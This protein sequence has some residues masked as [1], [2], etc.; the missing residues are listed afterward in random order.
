MKPATFVRSRPELDRLLVIDPECGTF[1][2]ARLGDLGRF[3]RAGD[4]VV[5]ND[6]ATLPA[7][8]DAVSSSGE[9]FELRLAGQGDS[10][11]DWTAV[12]LGAGPF[13]SRTEDRPP[14]PNLILS[15]RID[16]LHD[17]RRTGISQSGAHEPTL[18]AE[19][20]A[21]PHARLVR[22][23][24]DRE[25]AALWQALYRA[26]RPIQYAYVQ[27]PLSLWDV[28]TPFATRPWA[29][30]MP[31]AGR[32]LVAAV[33]A[34]L[35]TRGVSLARI[36]HAAGLSSTGDADLDARLP[37]PERYDVPE[38]TARAIAD[39]RARGGRVIAI[40]T[41][42]VR[43]LESAANADGGVRAESG[44]TNL[45]LSAASTP[46]V[47]DGVLSGL[48]EPDTSHFA[49][50]SAFAPPVLLARAAIHAAHRGYLGHELGD[51]CLVLRGARSAVRAS[52]PR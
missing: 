42:V 10:E 15:E 33:R 4:V 3:L 32:G 24:F 18:S 30:E 22:L 51:A 37:F 26:G 6:A 17:P 1:D 35:T 52:S 13:G 19:V 29:V 23:R 2:D 41:T 38:A 50:L 36:T 40:G 27:A 48:H 12:L 43:A 8:F 46:R 20:I 5:V 9:R 45:R 21:R 31:S 14:P 16:V 39:T 25:G 44:V 49:L 47:V 7:A 11:R 34:G 28:Q